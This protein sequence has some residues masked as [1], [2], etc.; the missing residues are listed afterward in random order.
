[1][2]PTRW[3][4]LGFDARESR[5]DDR[6]RPIPAAVREELLL[7][8]E[9]E[10]PFSVDTHIWPTHFLYYPRISHLIGP[11]EPPLIGADPDC[12]GGLWLNLARMRGRIAESGRAVVFIAVELLAPKDTTADEFPSPLIYSTPEPRSVPEGS[13]VLGFDVA[14]AGMDCSGLNCG[15]GE[16]EREKLRSEWGSRINNF[17]L[18]QTE[19]GAL[20]FRDLTEMLD[21]QHGPYW[22]YRLSRLPA[23]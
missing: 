7:R 8:P 16:E 22:V 10:C 12:D 14:N 21:S 5:Q 18:L 1:M 19:Q 23:S 20:E 13:V 17:G 15:Y 6:T 3:R 2:A 11:R 9:I 4:L